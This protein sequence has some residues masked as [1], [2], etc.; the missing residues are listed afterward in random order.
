[1][2]KP[3]VDNATAWDTSCLSTRKTRDYFDNRLYHSYCNALDLAVSYTLH[4]LF[5]QEF[6][7]LYI[8]THKCNYISYFNPQEIRTQ[9][10]LISLSE[11]W[12]IHV[13]GQKYCSLVECC[14]ALLAAYS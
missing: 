7:V 5:I 10:N 3:D 13:L 4:F 11:L 14:N 6:E 12:R 9:I 8:W 1:L 2:T